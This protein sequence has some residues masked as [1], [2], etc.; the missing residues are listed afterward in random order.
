MMRGLLQS[1]VNGWEETFEAMT[2]GHYP[3]T[4]DPTHWAAAHTQGVNLLADIST[5]KYLHFYDNDGTNYIDEVFTF[6][7]L[8]VHTNSSPLN[9]ITFIV[10]PVTAGNAVA[11]S[12]YIL[13]EDGTPW[14]YIRVTHSTGAVYISTDGVTYLD[15]SITLNLDANNTIRIKLTAVNKF[16]ANVNEAG[17]SAD[18]TIGSY[19][20]GINELQIMTEAANSVG[21][22]GILTTVEDMESLSVASIHGQSGPLGDY[23]IV[24]ASGGSTAAIETIDGQKRLHTIDASDGAGRIEWYLGYSVDG[25]LGA[26]KTC[27][28]AMAV[29]AGHANSCLIMFYEGALI[30]KVNLYFTGDGKMYYHNGV[31]ITTD[32]GLTVDLDGSWHDW[33]VEFTS[34]TTFRLRKDSGAWTAELNVRAA[35]SGTTGVVDGFWWYTNNG[36]T[37]NVE[38]DDIDLSWVKKPAVEDFEAYTEDSD[39]FGDTL[40]VGTLSADPGAA[41]DL[42]YDT[43]GGSKRLRHIQTGGAGTDRSYKLTFTRSKYSDFAGAYFQYTSRVTTGI[44]AGQSLYFYGKADESVFM[45]ITLKDGSV[46]GYDS[47][48]ANWVATGATPAKDTDVVIRLQIVDTTHYDIWVNGVKYTNSGSHWLVSGTIVSLCAFR[49]YSWDSGVQNW[50]DDISCSWIRELTIEDFEGFTHPSQDIA[51]G[52][53]TANGD[54]AACGASCESTIVSEGSSYRWR[55]KNAGAAGADRSITFQ[56]DDVETTIAGAVWYFTLRLPSTA[57]TITWYVHYDNGG[58]NAYAVNFTS[59]NL[60]VPSGGGTATLFAYSANTNYVIEMH[61]IDATHVYYVINGTVYD[62]GGGGYVV[63]SASELGKITL[64]NW[65]TDGIIYVDDMAMSWIG[66]EEASTVYPVEMYMDDINKY[67]DA[68]DGEVIGTFP[69]VSGTSFNGYMIRL[70]A[71]MSGSP[72]TPLDL[73]LSEDGETSH[74]D[75][76]VYISFDPSD[77][78]VYVLDSS[79]NP[80]DTGL[81]WTPDTEEEWAIFMVSTT[82]IRVGKYVDNWTWTEKMECRNEWTAGVKYLI[83]LTDDSD[84]VKLDDIV[85]SW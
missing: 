37:S 68:G 85:Y 59:G 69:V 7:N 30:V 50:L 74:S 1:L 66:E 78:H 81:E 83:A 38:I 36:S 27:K 56:T 58:V 11:M 42:T 34:T 65:N 64:Y 45:A 3:E 6:K 28:W 31:S 8:R 63:A 15:A 33:E 13:R 73:M 48:V 49:L 76:R 24:E 25:D 35:W 10:K 26:G 41:A 62:N 43:V 9:E 47:G 53:A 40:I 44:S 20:N 79:G 52:V 72:P 46:A 23:T 61:F 54:I 60:V 75:V 80:I 67:Q 21:G 70:K 82:E 12:Y 71:T 19:T 39:A 51:A 32:S 2:V 14:L 77:N 17:W 55:H 22:G 4:D 84:G 16:Q 5:G 57:Y 29:N 18:V